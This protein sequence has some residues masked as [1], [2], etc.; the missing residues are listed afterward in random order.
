M[1]TGQAKK[2]AARRLHNA[3]VTFSGISAQNIAFEDLAR[4]SKVFVTVKGIVPANGDYT[5][6]EAIQADKTKGYVL[7]IN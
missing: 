5:V 2:D 6:V 3:G 7:R 1:N 4:G